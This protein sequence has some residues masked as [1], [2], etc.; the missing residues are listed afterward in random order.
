MKCAPSPHVG[1]AAVA[2]GR[3]RRRAKGRPGRRRRADA[4]SLPSS[5]AVARLRPSLP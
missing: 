2:N 3:A 1:E 4:G 5:D